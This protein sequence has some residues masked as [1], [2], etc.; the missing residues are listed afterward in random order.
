MSRDSIS[1]L[2][3]VLTGTALWFAFAVGLGIARS[4]G[5]L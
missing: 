2:A 3:V 4:N 5:L 1:A